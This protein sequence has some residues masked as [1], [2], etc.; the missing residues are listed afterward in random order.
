MN[1]AEFPLQ[2]PDDSTLN[3]SGGSSGLA[4]SNDSTSMPTKRMKPTPPSPAKAFMVAASPP[5]FVSFDQLMSAANGVTNMAL[6]HEIAVDNNFKLEK[7]EP[8]SNSIEKQVKEVMHKAFWDSLSEKLSAEPPDYSHAVVLLEE[9][10][11]MLLEVL[12][13]QHTRLRTLINEVLDMEL[14][15]QKIANNALD[16]HYYAEF[17]IG[18]MAQLCAPA[19]DDSIREL[20]DQKE[21]VPLFREMF[22]I[23]ELMKRDMANYTIQQMRPYIQSQSVEYEKQKFTDF[24]KA[25]QDVGVDGLELTKEWL[26]RS[27]SRLESL[28]KDVPAS[29]SITMVTPASILNQAYME[30]FSWDNER[31]Y[32]E[33]L[34]MDQSRFEDLREKTDQIC[35]VSAILL[36]TYN[37]VGPSISGISELKSTLTDQISI[38]LESAESPDVMTN[39]ADQVALEVGKSL[40]K[41]GFQK[42]TEEKENHLKAQVKEVASLEHAVHK[43]LRKRVHDFILQT[44]QPAMQSGPLKIP[45]GVSAM[46]KPLSQLL[47]LDLEMQ[48]WLRMISR[49]VIFFVYL[50]TTI[51]YWKW[52]IKVQLCDIRRRSKQFL[53]MPCLHRCKNSS[54]PNTTAAATSTFNDKSKLEAKLRANPIDALT[55]PISQK[56]GRTMGGKMDYPVKAFSEM[57][58][59]KGLPLVGT[60]LHY[61]V[62][63]P[64]DLKRW[65]G[66]RLDNYK[67]YGKIYKEKIGPRWMVHLFDPKDVS[68]YLNTPEK[69][70]PDRGVSILT[71]IHAKERKI[72]MGLSACDGE[73]WYRIRSKVQKLF[74]HPKAASGYLDM[75]CDIADDFTERMEVLMD[76]NGHIP[77]YYDELYRFA[78]E[79]TGMVC[80]NRRTDSLNINGNPECDA[81]KKNL[82]TLF[83]VV[84]E[85]MMS[86]P[87]HKLFKTPM[88]RR[89]EKAWDEIRGLTEKHILTTIKELEEQERDGT[90]DLD[91]PN[92]L[93]TLL[94][95]KELTF[96]EIVSNTADFFC[97]GIDSGA[98]TL[99]F[100]LY[101]LA[102][103][104]DK[105]ETLIEEIERELPYCENPTPGHMNKL[106]Y[107]KACVKESFRMFYPTPCGPVKVIKEDMVI[108]GYKI[109]PGTMILPSNSVMCQMEEYFREPKKFIPERWLRD[110]NGVCEV[111]RTYSNIVLPFGHGMRVCL[112]RRFA[113]QEINLGIIKILQ[114]FNVTYKGE[115]MDKINK[116]FSIPDKPLNLFFTRRR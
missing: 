63:G 29:S 111:P 68:T 85:A 116:G 31:L 50:Y 56:F 67:K 96:G 27:K 11:Q 53:N 10:K 90:L 76:E 54:N 28:N 15:K 52:H 99:S 47:G 4:S 98:N 59:P 37:T 80:F 95:R 100:L 86:V 51:T 25:Q 12:L 114:K 21:I 36:I 18:I 46:E 101:N 69:G 75:Q 60:A 33:T 9:V 87:W 32:P 58:G 104:P 107:L 19:R 97:G 106:N 88:Y 94:A 8:D 43:L 39:I 83:E 20:K 48:K 110:E 16:F 3:S 108:S 24:L 109:P 91:K 81:L 102:T 103:N 89:F 38:L 84:F 14:I 73:E 2:G 115:P 112:G 77:N 5:Q 78:I 74:L 57:P 6:A 13:P 65:D 41:H 26:E 82:H 7:F 72:P 34:V 93:Y 35:L 113:E 92:F 49:C 105:Q 62:L 22:A 70:Y 64:Y 79:Y 66:P 23:L 45:P 30:I 44:T 61:S 42:M 40:E 55:C 71:Q 1:G 17:V